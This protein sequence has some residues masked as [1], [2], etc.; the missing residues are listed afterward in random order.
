MVR[1]TI[2][3][4]VAAIGLVAA[5]PGPGASLTGAYGARNACVLI[6]AFDQQSNLLGHGSGFILTN[7][8]VVVT[9]RHVV[10]DARRANGR[11][12]VI[13]PSGTEWAIRNAANADV[14][15]LRD[16]AIV[17]TGERSEAYLKLADSDR[18]REGQAVYAIGTPLSPENFNTVTKGVLLGYSENGDVVAHVETHPGSSG[19][20]LVDER[21]Q[22][23]GVVWGGQ[24]SA[25]ITLALPSNALEEFAGSYSRQMQKQENVRTAARYLSLGQQAEQAGQASTAIEHYEAALSHDPGNERAHFALGRL[26]QESDLA[27]S[28]RHYSAWLKL[29]PGKYPESEIARI[30]SH[31]QSIQRHLEK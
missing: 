14:A 15:Y 6:L 4:T 1:R 13:L 27:A 18:L 17:R 24:E 3:F 26:Y 8:G 16:L 23:I 22:L 19:G 21:G 31:V 29:A 28:L 11:L 5:F 25:R 20:P 9:N 10:E 30:R 12:A 2:S 7:S